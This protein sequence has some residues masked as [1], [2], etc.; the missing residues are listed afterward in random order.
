LTRTKKLALGAAA[1]GLGP[2]VTAVT[3]IVSVPVFLSAWGP[4]AYGQW[5]LISAIPAYISVA[6]FGVATAASNTI[7]A[8]RLTAERGELV[9]IFQS[10]LALTTA[11]ALAA[12]LLAVGILSSDQFPLTPDAHMAAILLAVWGFSNLYNSAVDAAFRADG[13]Y[14]T[15]PF[16][17]NM[18]RLF[19]WGGG[20][21]ALAISP[22]FSAVAA[23]F[24]GVRILGVLILLELSRRRAGPGWWGLKQ[25]RTAR[26]REIWKPAMAFALYPLSNAVLIQGSSLVIG[27]VLGPAAVAVYNTYRTLTRVA[28]QALTLVNRTFWPHFSELQGSGNT[29]GARSLLRQ[30]ALV[31]LMIGG[32]S[33]G[34]CLLA[35]EWLVNLLSRGKLPFDFALLACLAAGVLVTSL[36]QAAWVFL[37]AANAHARFSIIYLMSAPVLVLVTWICTQHFGLLGAAVV[38]LVHELFVA[39]VLRRLIGLGIK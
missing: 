29:R 9:E 13:D 2:A 10:A 7:T 6:D 37:M 19:E 34:A 33:A 16:T 20:M 35:G 1:N 17:L 5:L 4:A 38:L 21:A 32:A 18:L 36:W 23:G 27:A 15:G 12:L 25:A 28:T 8:R 26:M 3:T 14:L 24:L 11:G 39:V 30:A 22:Q 31:N